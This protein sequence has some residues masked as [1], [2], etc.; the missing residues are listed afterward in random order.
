MQVEEYVGLEPESI[1]ERMK[2]EK[3]NAFTVKMPLQQVKNELEGAIEHI[4]DKQKREKIV[5]LVVN[6]LRQKFDAKG[7]EAL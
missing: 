2:L 6:I 3:I 4:S 5:A 7:A 1:D